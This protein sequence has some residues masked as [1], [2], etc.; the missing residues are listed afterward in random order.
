M[1]KSVV[2]SRIDE[3]DRLTRSPRMI[4]IAL[5]GPRAPSAMRILCGDVDSKAEE[6]LERRI[7]PP[8]RVHSRSWLPIGEHREECSACSSRS[9]R[10]T[11]AG[12]RPPRAAG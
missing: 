11:T 5:D 9:D 1:A 3:L 2:S 4:D 7:V 12:P 10:R 6:L 8:A